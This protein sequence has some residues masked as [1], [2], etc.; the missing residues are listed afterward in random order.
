[1]SISLDLIPTILDNFSIHEL[2]MSENL[3]EIV[4]DEYLRRRIKRNKK[5]IKEFIPLAER[6]AKDF[7]LVTPFSHQFLPIN[8]P[9][10]RKTKINHE[11][12]FQTWLKFDDETKK[13][14]VEEYCRYFIPQIM[15]RYD[16]ECQDKWKNRDDYGNFV[17]ITR[18]YFILDLCYR[19]IHER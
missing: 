9:K 11:T 18:S 3:D 17:E 1:M 15:D 16:E 7:Q 8:S 10:E 2:I 6:F 12:A 19:K 4:A 5:W 14:C 13:K